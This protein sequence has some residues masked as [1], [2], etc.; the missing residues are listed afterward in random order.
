MRK[1]KSV[2]LMLTMGGFQYIQL[3]AMEA[4]ADGDGAEDV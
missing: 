2:L 3:E 4:M 1:Q